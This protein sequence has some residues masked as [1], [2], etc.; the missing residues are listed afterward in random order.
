MAR[1][2]FIAVIALVVFGTG[3]AAGRAQV[4]SPDFELTIDAPA[5]HTNVDCVRGCKLLWVSRGIPSGAT[6]NEHFDFRCSGA[7]RC[8]SGKIGG[9]VEP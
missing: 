9:W 7:D 1:K 3:W 4:P 6:P 2:I 8:G 5:G